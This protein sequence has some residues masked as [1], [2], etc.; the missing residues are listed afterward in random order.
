MSTLEK[1]I[2]YSKNS[3]A[4]GEFIQRLSSLIEIIT[5][6]KESV[7]AKVLSEY[8][9]KGLFNIFEELLKLS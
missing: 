5:D 1:A 2:Q 7:S 3:F 8:Y 9:T 4:S 6:S